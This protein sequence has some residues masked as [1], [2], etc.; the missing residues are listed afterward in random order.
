MTTHL[1]HHANGHY[2][3]SR[4]D[5]ESKAE[6]YSTAVL[7]GNQLVLIDPSEPPPQVEEEL[8]KLGR[9]SILFLTSGNHERSSE[10][11]RKKWGVP[12]A[13]S[14]AAV[15]EFRQKPDVIFE[16]GRAIHDL[17]PID[18]PGGAPGETA[19]FHEPSKTIILGD[20]VLN[21][22]E[23]PLMLLPE[24]YCTNSAELKESL[25]KLLAL[26]F[27]HLMFAHG[28]PILSNGKEQLAQLLK[29]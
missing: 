29:K 25:G 11:L 18:L 14:A 22:P 13:A 21:L 26:D 10:L 4:H 19:L 9:V 17:T 27:E 2:T 6:L 8:A 28:N 12:V 15:S 24:K 1:Q 23:Y 16:A 20:A 5:S 7:Y 3:W